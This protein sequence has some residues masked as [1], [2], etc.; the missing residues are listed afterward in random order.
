MNWFVSKTI[1]REEI[2]YY[3]KRTSV[4][5]TIQPNKIKNLHIYSANIQLILK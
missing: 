1:L 5:S 4:I 3:A 2:I